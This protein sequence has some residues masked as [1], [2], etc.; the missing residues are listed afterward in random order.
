MAL[1]IV[2]VRSAS[3]TEWDRVWA[4][5]PYATFSILGNGLKFGLC[6]LLAKCNPGQR[7]LS[8]MTESQP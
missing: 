3:D 8:S 2:S 4:A 5:C 6:I 1:E 7:W